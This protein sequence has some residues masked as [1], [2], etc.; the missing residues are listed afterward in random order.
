MKASIVENG[1]MVWVDMP[2]PIIKENEEF[3]KFV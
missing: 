2:D 3:V 1:K